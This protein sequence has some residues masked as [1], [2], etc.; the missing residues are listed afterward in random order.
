MCNPGIEAT[1][2]ITRMLAIYN[3]LKFNSIGKNLKGTIFVKVFETP[4]VYTIKVPS[5]V[6]S[7]IFT[8]IYL[9]FRTL[10]VEQVSRSIHE[11]GIIPSVF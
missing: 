5:E 4:F 6:E 1:S 8:I 3:V 9:L 11:L 7:L 10:E 2:L